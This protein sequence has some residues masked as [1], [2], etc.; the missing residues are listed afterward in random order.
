[1]RPRRDSSWT[2][3]G[4]P[5]AMM[6]PPG[7]CFNVVISSV[8]SPRAIRVSAQLARTRV[9]EKT[10]FGM[11]FIGAANPSVAVGQCADLPRAGDEPVE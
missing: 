1:M 4:P 3:V 8:T 7:C 2:N 6:S 10:T 5:W 11:L 9:L